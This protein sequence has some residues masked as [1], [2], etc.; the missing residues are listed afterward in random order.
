MGAWHK[1]D[2]G[3]SN[4]SLGLFCFLPCGSFRLSMTILLIHMVYLSSEYTAEQG[5]PIYHT[6]EQSSVCF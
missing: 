1:I 3:S 6:N 4:P 5:F 2:T